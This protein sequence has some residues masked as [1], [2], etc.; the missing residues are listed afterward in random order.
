M[1]FLSR[2]SQLE[3][4]LG[5]FTPEDIAIA[6][7]GNSEKVRV[8]A[9]LCTAVLLTVH[10]MATRLGGMYKSMGFGLPGL[11]SRLRKFPYDPVASEN[12]AWC[13]AVV[14][15]KIIESKADGDF[16]TAIGTSVQ[17]TNMEIARRTD[18]V[19]EKGIIE[20]SASY[21]AQLV[22]AESPRKALEE[23]ERNLAFAISDRRMRQDNEKPTTRTLQIMNSVAASIGVD[24]LSV[25]P[26]LVQT[27][28]RF[29]QLDPEFGP[30][31][32]SP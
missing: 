14:L 30:R 5:S 16:V 32:E 7:T 11:V 23:Y 22:G 3:K 13:H 24:H 26:G 20:R 10:Q 31:P 15:S 28:K 6:Y 29:R 9:A 18:C 8:A 1:S 4:Y 27:A 19:S 17:L 21:L 12:A 2:P 25:I